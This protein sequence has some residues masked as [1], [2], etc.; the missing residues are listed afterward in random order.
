[1]SAVAF[2]VLIISSVQTNVLCDIISSI[3]AYQ[4]FHE[5]LTLFK[6]MKNKEK[7]NGRIKGIIMMQ[8][9]N[10]NQNSSFI[11]PPQLPLLCEISGVIRLALALVLVQ[12]GLTS[13][14]LADEVQVNFEIFKTQNNPLF[15]LFN[16]GTALLEQ[17][18]SN[19]SA[20][21][22]KVVF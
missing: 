18:K 5:F 22:F 19:F 9:T 14:W 8:W 16:K 17:F 2:S 1:M 3:T 12:V 13:S 15:T 10:L 21:Y 4:H 11:N 7:G 20:A 6:G